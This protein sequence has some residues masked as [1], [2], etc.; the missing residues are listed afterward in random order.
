MLS[1]IQQYI[2]S[3]SSSDNSG[4]EPFIIMTFKSD[5]SVCMCTCTHILHACTLCVWA[6]YGIVT[7]AVVGVGQR[8]CAL[9]VSVL[10]QCSCSLGW[11][12]S[13]ESVCVV[14]VSWC[15]SHYVR[16]NCVFDFSHVC[17]EVYQNHGAILQGKTVC[18]SFWCRSH[19][20]GWTKC[21]C[22]CMCECIMVS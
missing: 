20:G 15:H 12:C 8:M 14:S 3:D 19:Y 7:V 1:V 11:Q 9:S 16:L 10:C 5:H 17:V 4:M 22:L 13:C 21:T 2:I 6:L 18:V